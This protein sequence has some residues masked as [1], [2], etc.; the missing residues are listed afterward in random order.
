VIDTG[1]A[2]RY[3]RALLSLASEE[4]RHEQLA[5]E[6]SQ[7]LRTMRENR[8]LGFL[9]ETPGYSQ[10]QRR[11]AVDALGTALSLSPLLMKF[12]RL[13]VERQRTPDL[14]AIQRAYSALLDQQ[15]GRVRATVTAAQPLSPDEVKKLRDTLAS[16]TGQ[17]VVLEAKTD[18][19]IL[20]GVVTQVGPTQYDG[21]LK[22]QLDKLRAELKQA[23]V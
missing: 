12:L 23:P 6:L 13:L 20:G 14:A 3:A 1:V 11:A 7:V 9:L 17:S 22:T 15:V 16:L 2:R 10:E 18:P 5:D 8:E 21:S 4:G 19:R